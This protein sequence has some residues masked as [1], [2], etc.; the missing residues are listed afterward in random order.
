VGDADRGFFVTTGNE[1]MMQPC[2][3]PERKCRRPALATV[4]ASVGASGPHGFAVRNM[5]RSS[6]RRKTAHKPDE[7]LP[8]DSICAPTLSRPPHPA[9][10]P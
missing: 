2:L 5:H 1:V 4:A 6:A 8:C 10:R 3:D 7:G 9:P